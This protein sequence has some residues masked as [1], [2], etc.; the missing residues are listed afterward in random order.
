MSLSATTNYFLA[1]LG[2]NSLSEGHDDKEEEIIFLI[3]E[4][5]W[6]VRYRWT[7]DVGGG[8]DWGRG[9]GR[10]SDGVVER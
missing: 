7:G 5:S 2:K 9:Q 8:G 3:Y 10:L 6:L 4:K 1:S